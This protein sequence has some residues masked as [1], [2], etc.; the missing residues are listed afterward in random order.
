MSVSIALLLLTLMLVPISLVWWLGTW[1]STSVLN[2]KSQECRV[3]SWTRR[4][5]W[6]SPV[7]V[8]ITCPSCH[9]LLIHPPP[10]HCDKGHYGQQRVIGTF[11]LLFPTNHEILHQPKQR[12][13][14]KSFILLITI[15]NSILWAHGDNIMT[16]NSGNN[17]R[18]IDDSHI[19]C[20][21][22]NKR[23]WR[24]KERH[25]DLCLHENEPRIIIPVRF[26]T[27]RAALC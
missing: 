5:S 27:F 9:H 20:L 4:M 26:L 13:V 3:Y 22:D 23:F 19:R 25:K 8:I 7:P 2:R 14:Q 16:Y 10:T 6:H 18:K 1:G 21:R 12:T 24:I 11:G 17:F 15:W